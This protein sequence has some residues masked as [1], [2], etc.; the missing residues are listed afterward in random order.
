MSAEIR[1]LEYAKVFS[2]ARYIWYKFNSEKPFKLTNTRGRKVSLVKGNKYGLRKA[3]SS[4]G[5]YR[6]ISPELGKTIIFSL[7][8][9]LAHKLMKSSIPTKH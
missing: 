4:K 7:T 2:E 5:M 8:E 3:T 6:F 1:L 9:P